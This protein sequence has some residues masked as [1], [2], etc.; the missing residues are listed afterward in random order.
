MYS[1]F[2]AKVLVGMCLISGAALADTA[3]V[4]AAKA[5]IKSALKAKFAG[6]PVDSVRK[7]PYDGLYEFVSDNQVFYTDRHV[8]YILVGRLIDAKSHRDLTEERV[9]DLMQVKFDTLPLDAA[10][11]LV[12]GNGKRKMAVFSDPDCPYCKRLEAELDKIDDVTIYLFLYPV[13]LLHAGSTQKAKSVWCAPDR[14]KA[15]SELMHKGTVP[16]GGATCDTPVEKIRALAAKLKING[17]PTLVFADG[18][19]VPGAI[20][21]AQMEKLLG[22]AK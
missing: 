10:I 5:A 3:K 18:Q 17:T 15:W 16:Q 13:E 7:M 11:K 19:R 14:A 12:K 21:A 2:V 4:D 9:R 1:K 22:S 8:S 6:I 20:P